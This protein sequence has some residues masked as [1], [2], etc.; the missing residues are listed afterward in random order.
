[1]A[2]DPSQDRIR[3][4]VNADDFGLS[5]SANRAIIR[6][7]REGILTSASLMV[8]NGST[9]EDA[10]ERAKENPGL[11]VGLHLTLVRGKSALKGTE[12]NG[13]VSPRQEFRESP[14]LAGLSY[15]F[16]RSLKAP[17]RQEIDAQ[18]KRF[19]VCG[20]PLDHVN[21][22]L[23]FHLHPV[24]FN[25]IKRHYHAWGIYA[26][27]LPRDPL[28]TNLRLAFFRS[29]WRS[30]QSLIFAHLS[31]RAIPPLQRRG[32]RHADQVFGLLQSGHMDE[33]YLLRVLE[34]LYPG[35]FEIYL[36]PD[37]DEHAHELEALLS[38]RVRE[39]IGQRNIE[40]IRYRDLR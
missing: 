8:T 30:P 12:L 34:N 11:G 16:R 37:E 29:L 9:S 7:H 6:A 15:Y 23:H 39:I 32:I 28:L 13:L 21:G 17:L 35:V 14:V 24:I 25:S 27:R 36:H 33:K 3:L 18:F 4:I 26:L 19:R 2:S 10:V 20:L 5:R 22:H 38:P 40:L 1:M 31:S